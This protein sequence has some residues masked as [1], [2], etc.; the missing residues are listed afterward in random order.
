MEPNIARLEACY[1][2]NVGRDQKH[3]N[4]RYWARRTLFCG[5]T[6][7]MIGK[8][9]TANPRCGLWIEWSFCDLRASLRDIGGRGNIGGIADHFGISRCDAEFLF[10]PHEGAKNDLPSRLSILRAFIDNHK[11]I[12]STIPTMDFLTTSIAV[13]DRKLALEMV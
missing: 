13:V 2:A 1:Q 7:C 4:M 12:E 5:T 10:W 9:V 11:P 6:H 8:Y 3:F